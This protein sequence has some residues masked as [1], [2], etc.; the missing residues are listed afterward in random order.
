MGLA[1]TRG[2][3]QPRPHVIGE[4]ESHCAGG[5]HEHQG[6]DERT[7]GGAGPAPVSAS[8]GAVLMPGRNTGRYRVIA[9][10]AGS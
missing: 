6:A 1:P 5:N 7:V 3:G 9:K 4:C 10:Q 2:T 8:D